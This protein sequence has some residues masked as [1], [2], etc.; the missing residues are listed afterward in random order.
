MMLISR[1]SRL[2]QADLHSVLDHVEEPEALLRQAVREMEDIFAQDQR[3]SR[4]LQQ[5]HRQLILR[6]HKL[7]TDL[8]RVGEELEVCFQSKE[9]DLARKLIKRQLETRQFC[10]YLAEK[11]TNLEHSVAEVGS[12]LEENRSRLVSMRQK[13]ELFAKEEPVGSSE[14]NWSVPDYRVTDEDVEV[15]LLREKQK[16]SQT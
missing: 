12:R 4:R 15:A 8:D 7:E 11:R 14:D 3:L 10:R 13:I 2:F 9:E 1:I 6:Q 16:R 5:E